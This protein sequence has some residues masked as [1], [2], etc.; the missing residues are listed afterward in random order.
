MPRPSHTAAG[1]GRRAL[2]LAIVFQRHCSAK[3]VRVVVAHRLRPVGGPKHEHVAAGKRPEDRLLHLSFAGR[4]MA[5][6]TGTGKDFRVWPPS[7]GKML[8]RADSNRLQRIPTTKIPKAA[9]RQRRLQVS[10]RSCYCGITGMS[11]YVPLTA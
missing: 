5:A 4:Q 6:M 8:L 1:F 7:F 9:D 11:S 2:E 10:L 3:A